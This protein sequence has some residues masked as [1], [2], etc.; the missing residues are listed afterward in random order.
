MFDIVPLVLE[1]TSVIR[2]MEENLEMI[3]GDRFL[4]AAKLLDGYIS[5]IKKGGGFLLLMSLKWMIGTR[6]R[7]FRPWILWKQQSRRYLRKCRRDR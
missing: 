5:R 6:L 3:L 4:A 2:S 7:T 1:V